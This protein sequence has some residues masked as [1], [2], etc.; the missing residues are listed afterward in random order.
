LLL[1]LVGMQK[2]PKKE[3]IFKEKWL[4]GGD[5]KRIFEK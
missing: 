4:G 1:C 5:E 2:T 3:I